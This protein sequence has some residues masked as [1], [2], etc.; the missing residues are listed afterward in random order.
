MK[1]NMDYKKPIQSGFNA[2]L[3]G[4]SNLDCPADER[5]HA[6]IRSW[7][8]QGW[9]AGERSKKC[10]GFQV[11]GKDYSGCDMKSGKYPMGDCPACI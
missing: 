7:W 8:M 6:N 4:V 5:W 3:E 9:E 10:K 1:N 2:S 11:H